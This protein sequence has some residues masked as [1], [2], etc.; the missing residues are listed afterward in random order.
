M[1]KLSAAQTQKSSGRCC[2]KCGHGKNGGHN[3]RS[4]TKVIYMEHVYDFDYYDYCCGC[5]YDGR[6]ALAKAG[7]V[8]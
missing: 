1:A 2:P 7:M 8:K 5:K 6:V 3:G 4:C